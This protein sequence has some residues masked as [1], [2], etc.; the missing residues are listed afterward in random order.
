MDAALARQTDTREQSVLPLI[1]NSKDEVFSQY[2]LLR[3]LAYRC[4]D[5]GVESIAA[6]MAAISGS[7]PV[8]KSGIRVRVESV[9]S[10]RLFDIVETPRVSID[11][12]V[13]KASSTL[14]GKERA[15]IG[16]LKLLTVQWILVDVNA[17]DYWDGL[18]ESK[19]RELRAVVKVGDKIKTTNVGTTT[20]EE[21]EVPSGT[22]FH[23][24]GITVGSLWLYKNDPS[25][26]GPNVV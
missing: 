23:L 20:L 18:T 15:D 17:K 3:T 22:V 26:T 11:W 24:C 5:Q 4:F 14:G 7:P 21:L 9:H 8:T 1:L 6:E 2:P 25:K 13:S 10:G 19:Q 12:L 16:A